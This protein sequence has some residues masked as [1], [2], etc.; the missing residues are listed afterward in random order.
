MKLKRTQPYVPW[1]SDATLRIFS[2]GRLNP[3]KG[4]EYLI[5]AT[6]ILQSS[7]INVLLE[8]AGEDEKGGKGYH[9]TLDALIVE[10]GA[11]DS[12]KLLGAISEDEVVEK[13]ENSHIFALASLHEPLGVAI[14]EAMAMEVPVVATDSGGV[15]ELVSNNVDGILVPPKDSEALAK[16]IKIIA[17]SSDI[18]SCLSK[19]ARSRIISDFQDTLSAEVLVQCLEMTCQNV[20]S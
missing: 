19:N 10:I 17:Q 16:V 8:I 4:H 9:K 13:L 20:S 14:M 2:C 7:G 15:K 18:S 6:G 5:R 12:V 3:C 11:K 1:T